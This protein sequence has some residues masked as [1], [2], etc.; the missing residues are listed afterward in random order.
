LRISAQLA[1]TLGT[2]E[3]EGVVAGNTISLRILMEEMLPVLTH[4][5]SLIQPPL[6]TGP[7][8]EGSTSSVGDVAGSVTDS[9]GVASATSKQVPQQGDAPKPATSRVGSY[10]TCGPRNSQSLYPADSTLQLL[11]AA[12]F[13]LASTMLQ[14]NVSEIHYTVLAGGLQYIGS[15]TST[16]PDNS[17]NAIAA[18]LDAVLSL[19]HALVMK[20]AWWQE[21]KAHHPLLLVDTLRSIAKVVKQCGQGCHLLIK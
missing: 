1:G 9:L 17:S 5:A 13:L 20:G 3:E 15:N 11:I 4:V 16:L 18:A 2:V 21:A 7:S 6:P 12:G 8:A 19:T 14:A 10:D